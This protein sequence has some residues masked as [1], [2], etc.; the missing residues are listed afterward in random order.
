MHWRRND[1]L[2]R[3]RRVTD[4]HR[5]VG[6]FCGAQVSRSLPRSDSGSDRRHRCIH[7]FPA[8]VVR[9]AEERTYTVAPERWQ[10]VEQLYSGALAADAGGRD[11]W[12][13]EACA[14]DATS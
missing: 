5:L 12:L 9:W 8:W 14:G 1:R 10:H 6:E 4:W 3:A 11:A 2:A 7:A 13:D